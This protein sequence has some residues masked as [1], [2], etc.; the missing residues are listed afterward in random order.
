MT[1]GAPAVTDWHANGPAPY[2]APPMTSTALSSNTTHA[3]LYIGGSVLL[4]HM[5]APAPLEPMT[6]L[7][8][9]AIVCVCFTF[10][11]AMVSWAFSTAG[12]KMPPDL[13]TSPLTRIW[14]PSLAAM[15]LGWIA[16]RSIEAT[17]PFALRFD[18][19]HE[20]WGLKMAAVWVALTAALHQ[21]EHN[22]RLS[23]ELM[24]LSQQA[25][26]SES[27][28]NADHEVE[29]EADGRRYRVSTADI[30]Y[31]EAEE[32]YCR[33]HRAGGANPLLVR[34]TLEKI[35]RM[36]PSHCIRTHRSFLVNLA[37][38]RE[39][40]REGR[41]FVVLMRDGRKAPIAR[42]R[43]EAFTDAWRN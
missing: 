35:S 27:A 9:I 28:G 10:G 19:G 18:H 16:F 21:S 12:A 31:V 38:A 37:H 5:L 17:A 6:T 42:A 34:S 20:D 22:R 30:L 4:V 33:I 40:Q 24:A 7:L 43:M 32:N 15:A 39:V 25:R 29:L 23:A 26:A 3:A 1:N 11:Y 8:H 41:S 36:L 14:A 2:Y 13:A